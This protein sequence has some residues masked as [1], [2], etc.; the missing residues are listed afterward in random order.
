MC[1]QELLVP[2]IGKLTLVLAEFDQGAHGG[3]A[4]PKLTRGLAKNIP[5][6]HQSNVKGYLPPWEAISHSTSHI[7]NSAGE[8]GGVWVSA[9]PSDAAKSL[10]NKNTTTA[11]FV[12]SFVNLHRLLLPGWPV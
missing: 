5:I 3:M 9:L 1:F 11:Y 6:Y 10:A 8:T 12:M 4:Y 7:L 2:T